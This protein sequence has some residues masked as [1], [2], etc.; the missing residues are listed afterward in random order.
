MKE[1]LLVS[2]NQK[3]SME[4]N[5]VRLEGDVKRLNEENSRLTR[6]SINEQMMARLINMLHDN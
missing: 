5:V 4:A 1:E 6:L 2:R 3:E